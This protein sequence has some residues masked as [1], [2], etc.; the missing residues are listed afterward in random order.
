MLDA[1]SKLQPG[2]LS[3]NTGEFGS[4]DQC[5]QTHTLTEYGEIRGQMCAVDLIPG[6]RLSGHI[7]RIRGLPQN[8]KKFIKLY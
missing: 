4:Y 1:S 6:P 8:V 2:V 7:I 5:L 3:G